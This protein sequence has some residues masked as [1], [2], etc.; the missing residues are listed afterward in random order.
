MNDLT[1]KRWCKT[2]APKVVGKDNNGNFYTKC[3][4]GHRKNED[5]EIVI[6]KFEG[7]KKNE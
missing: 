7:V 2:H 3:Y 5:C 1:E 4:V 6:E